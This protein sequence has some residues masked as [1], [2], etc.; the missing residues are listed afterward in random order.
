MFDKDTCGVEPLCDS[1]P[2]MESLSMRPI[3]SIGAKSHSD[4][5]R[6]VVEITIR[7]RWM[8]R[9]IYRYLDT[10]YRLNALFPVCRI[11]FQTVKTTLREYH[12]KWN[13]VI[14]LWTLAHVEILWWKSIR[15][16]VLSVHVVEW[17]SCHGSDR[18]HIVMHI[19]REPTWFKRRQP[20]QA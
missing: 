8:Q 19:Y 2:N 20:I 13:Q 16:Q 9:R 1:S 17:V 18:H 7:V 15:N 4:I 3:G 5:D 10:V 14:V 11:F 6:V 12:Y